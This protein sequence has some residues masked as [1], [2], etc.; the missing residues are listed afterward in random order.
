LEFLQANV[1][2]IVQLKAKTNSNSNKRQ[3]DLPLTRFT[4]NEVQYQS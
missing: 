2:Q 4:F 1:T 3:R